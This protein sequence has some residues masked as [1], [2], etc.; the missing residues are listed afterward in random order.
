[1]L[2][3]TALIGIIVLLIGGGPLVWLIEHDREA[4]P[5]FLASFH[6]DF[7][8]FL[9]DHRDFVPWASVAIDDPENLDETI[10]R[11]QNLSEQ[12][13]IQEQQ[14]ELEASRE[15]SLTVSL[16]VT[17]LG[18][19]VIFWTLL[20]ACARG[21]ILSI[22]WII[23]LFRPKIKPSPS[24]DKSQEA[25]AVSS[26]IGDAQDTVETEGR[27]LQL[28]SDGDP[29]AV[30]GRAQ[31]GLNCGPRLIG[32]EEEGET[33]PYRRVVT[34]H[35][36]HGLGNPA[37]AP[38]VATGLEQTPDAT[39]P[40]ETA[41]G[42]SE[43]VELGSD[44]DI[45][46]G[47]DDLCQLQSSLQYQSASFDRQIEEFKEVAQ[48]VRASASEQSEPVNKAL[49]DLNDQ[50]SAIRD[51]ASH[52]QLRVEKLQN[53]YD[54]NIIRQFCLRIIRCID[55]IELRLDHQVD[56]VDETHPLWEVRDELL[57]ALESSGV[58]QFEP[59][60]NSVFQGQQRQA[61][62]V[63]EK[64]PCDDPSRTGCIA[65]IVKPGY[66]Y[67]IDEENSKT[68]RPARVK[69][70]DAELSNALSPEKPTTRG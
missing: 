17:A 16:V 47:A 1:M 9:G 66:R 50:I 67:V 44:D 3:K 59:E 19:L 70:Y 55:N 27:R 2:R 23:Q 8:V 24:S 69:L 4:V 52:Q 22:K 56:P 21:T 26:V 60:L 12:Q 46:A 15:F 7:S 29:V 39:L 61:E 20:L 40:M 36:D 58:E 53:G 28:D 11:I 51:Y 49:Q 14:T 18:G 30:A 43:E 34:L 68:V 6:E 45:A 35:Q 38:A 37:E 25:G 62:A 63:K 57:F 64:I 41:I 10:T 42:D 65:H 33:L 48:S 32:V 13:R 54:W 5:R 31:V